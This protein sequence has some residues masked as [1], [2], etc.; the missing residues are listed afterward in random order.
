MKPI[1]VR[2]PALSVLLKKNV[3]RTTLDGNL[4]V[5]T[6]YSGQQKTIDLTP[7]FGDQGSVRVS[8]SVREPA[9]AFVLTFADKIDQSAQDTVY[10]LVEPMD[11]IEIRMA[12]DGYLNAYSVGAA[13]PPVMMRGFVSNIRRSETMQANGQPQRA[14][15][16]S[17]QDYGK[18]WQILQV[19][20]MPNAPSGENLITSFPFFARFGLSF[21]TMPAEQ[22]VQEVFEKVINPYINDMASQGGNDPKTSP[23]LQIKPDMQI[24]DGNVSPFGAGGW[25]GGTIYSLLAQHCDLGVWNELY[26]EDRE[27]A[28]YVVYRPNPFM[29][30]DGKTYIMPV[31]KDKEPKIVPIERA[32]V[33]SLVSDRSDANVANYFWVDAP[34]FNL[35]YVET[36]RAMA[37]QGDKETFFVENYGNINPKLYGTRKMWEQTQQAGRGESDSGNG[38]PDGEP[39]RI[40]EVDAIAW[41]TKRRIQLIEQNR[42]NVVLENGTMR[43]KGNENIK[44]GT[45]VRLKNGNLESDYYAVNV[46]HDYVPFGTYTTTV[47]FERGTGFIDRVQKSGGKSSPYWAEVAD[48]S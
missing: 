36:M 6:R 28:P 38:T 37:Y 21:K 29:S 30:V 42:D 45:Y 5:S 15:I 22:F 19:F 1:K 26:I 17:G 47:S 11:V 41:M 20:F 18:I 12:G 35:N 39:R 43:L 8:K 27:D 10:G 32:D 9:G 16:I 33:V 44:S 4:P 23:L 2:Q 25:A 48:G 40:N 7:Y 24:N 14:V 13:M 31:E 3:G 34:R 46:Q